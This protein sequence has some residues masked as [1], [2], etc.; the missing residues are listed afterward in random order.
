MRSAS[1]HLRAHDYTRVFAQTASGDVDL[2]WY[3]EYLY[4]GAASGVVAVC[5]VDR[6]GNMGC[7]GLD[8]M[9]D[10]AADAGMPPIGQSTGCC[11]ANTRP[12]AILLPFGL[13]L[14]LLRRRKGAK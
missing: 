10:G 3:G 7:N 13:V 9:F 5:A 11:D 14:L 4:V 6:Q 12:S 8:G 2:K 1:R